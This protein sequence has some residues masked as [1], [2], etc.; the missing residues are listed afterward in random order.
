MAFLGNRDINDTVRFV[1]NTHSPDTGAAV[2]ADGL[3]TYRVY[4]ENTS[5]PIETGTMALFDSA[6]TIG[7][8]QQSF[9]ATAEAGFENNKSYKIFISATVGGIIGTISHFFKVGSKEMI[10][11]VDNA[12]S[13]ALG[14]PV[15]G[16]LS[17]TFSQGGNSLN[18]EDV[19]GFIGVTLVFNQNYDIPVTLTVR[20]SNSGTQDQYVR[21]TVLFGP[22]TDVITIPA[23][24]AMTTYTYAIDD[25]LN[26]LVVLF[27]NSVSDT[28]ADLKIDY[29]GITF[30]KKYN[31]FVHKNQY[32]PSQGAPPMATSLVQKINYLY[33][34]WRNKV[35]QTSST[36]SLFNDNTS[37]VD[38]KRTVSDD[39]TTF[40]RS[41][42]VS[43]P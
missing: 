38:H 12:Y 2:D 9:K 33:K 26:P 34:A 21:M 28:S 31:P 3:P 37:T 14:T 8:Y 11:I 25:A 13:L 35:T 16:A 5:T 36:H 43:G 10:P 19:G 15:S 22:N 17:D 27:A 40:T 42:M 41:V 39:G 1:V 23:A 4:E 32:E 7:L 6:N 29:V 30:L 20:A 24:T 18:F